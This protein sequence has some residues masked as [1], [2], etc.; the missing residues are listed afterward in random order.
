MNIGKFL[1]V[2]VGTRVLLNKL[3]INIFFMKIKWL[4]LIITICLTTNSFAQIDIF[5]I[6]KDFYLAEITFTNNET[7]R[8][9]LKDFLE[10][11]TFEFSGFGVGL[12]NLEANRAGRSYLIVKESKDAKPYKIPTNTIKTLTIFDINTEPVVFDMIKVKTITNNLETVYKDRDILVPLVRDGTVKMYVLTVLFHD[13]NSGKK[14][15]YTGISVTPLVYLKHKDQEYAYMPQDITVGSLFSFWTL[16]DKFIKAFSLPTK[17]CE[18][19]QTYLKE[20]SVIL[21][22]SENRKKTR[23]DLKEHNKF[24][25]AEAKKLDKSKRKRFVWDLDTKYALKRYY[26]FLEE[27]ENQCQ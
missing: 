6:K 7:K 9:L 5:F 19:F 23:Q 16:D 21:E 3:S 8:L 15:L 2:R 13:P 27:Y 20:Q 18:V 4:L 10:A 25:K 14:P 24:K 17:D 1:P 12:R 26:E 11:S 22:S